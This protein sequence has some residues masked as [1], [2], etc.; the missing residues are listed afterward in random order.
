MRG[1]HRHAAAFGDR[2]ACIAGGRGF[3][4]RDVQHAV[5]IDVEAVI[6]CILCVQTGDAGFDNAPMLSRKQC[7]ET[8][9][10]RKIARLRL[11]RCIV[12]TRRVYRAVG[13]IGLRR[14]RR[15]PGKKYKACQETSGKFCHETTCV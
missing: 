12:V 6:I 15:E 3:A 1:R 5:A 14:A 11:D 7:A 8:G 13:M 4:D 9:F 2:R 10:I